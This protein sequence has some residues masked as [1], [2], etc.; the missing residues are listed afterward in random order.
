MR[1]LIAAVLLSVGIQAQDD[2]ALIAHP[3]I[4]EQ[5]ELTPEQIRM[6]Y[7]EKQR[8]L[9]GRRLVPIQLPA[10]NVLRRKFERS[11]I[12]MNRDQWRAYWI[13]R[14]Y[15]GERPPRVAGSVS[16]AVAFVETICGAVAYVPRDEALE[17][18]VSILYEN[19]V[20][21]P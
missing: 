8:Y 13:R 11:V 1:R 3:C 5:I 15:L 4:P 7:L 18:N 17:A 20:T 2:W 21:L 16:A 14:H 10:D 6:I 12:G 9:E 19:P